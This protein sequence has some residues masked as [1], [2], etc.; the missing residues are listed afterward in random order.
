[1][2]D[3]IFTALTPSVIVGWFLMI[4]LLSYAGGWAVLAREYRENALDV[5]DGPKWNFQSASLRKWCGYN[6]CVA[7]V[8][9]ETG[10]RL[11]LWAIFRP[12]HPPLFL[13]YV[14]M[15]FEDLK[16]LGM[17]YTRVRMQKT[18][19]VTIDLSPKLLERFR[20][21]EPTASD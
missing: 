8:A 18:P 5:A 15:E 20:E 1:M 17:T 12:A 3:W 13:P 10:L 21:T 9:G 6:G 2:P 11:S 7:V 4:A 14:E 16:S 19:S